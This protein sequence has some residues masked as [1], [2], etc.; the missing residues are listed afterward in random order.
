[1]RAFRACA[2][3]KSR[4]QAQRRLFSDFFVPEVREWTHSAY[5]LSPWMI[6]FGRLSSSRIKQAYLSSPSNPRPYVSRAVIFSNKNPPLW[7]LAESI[8]L[9]RRCHSH[10]AKVRWQK[11]RRRDNAERADVEE[12]KGT[13]ESR[14]PEVG[15]PRYISTPAGSG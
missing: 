8:K 6:H 13:E 3:V 11:L 7:L 4:F 2:F 10:R 14:H 12:E 9:P 1:M 5:S 15:T